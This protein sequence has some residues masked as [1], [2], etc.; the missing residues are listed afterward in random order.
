M[1]LKF[2]LGL[3]HLTSFSGYCRYEDADFDPLSY[4]SV[5][6]VVECYEECQEIPNECV[7]FDY[8]PDNTGYECT[9]Y[10]GGPYTYGT[11]IVGTTCYLMTIGICR[12]FDVFIVL[13][14]ILC[15]ICTKISIA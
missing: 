3:V 10:K 9:M 11:G 12:D 4:S 13:V 6:S 14:L 7:A 1:S 8:S 15:R 2:F 5:T